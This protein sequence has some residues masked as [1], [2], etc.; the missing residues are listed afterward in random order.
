MED[1]SLGIWEVIK[2]VEGGELSHI[3]GVGL[4][5]PEYNI[6]IVRG[7]TQSMSKPTI[8]AFRKD[9]NK[10]ES[11]IIHELL[12]VCFVENKLKQNLYKDEDNKTM[13]HIRLFAFM[14]KFYCEIL[15]K[16]DSWKEIEKLNRK[17]DG[18]S[19]A[20]DIVEEDGYDYIIEN[21]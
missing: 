18:Y 17:Y 14:K 6:Y 10:F 15:D 11:E 9:Y 12:H 19:K 13:V 3:L 5:K 2:T 16:K 21:S 7:A 8:I 4:S 20:M 1:W